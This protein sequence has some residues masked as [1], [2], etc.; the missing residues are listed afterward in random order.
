MINDR[1]LIKKKLGVGRSSVFLCQDKEYPGNVM[2]MKI[3]PPDAEETESRFFIGEYFTLK[4]LNHPNIIKANELGTVVKIDNDNEGISLGSKY[5][6]LEYF[7]GQSLLDYDELNYEEVLIEIIKQLC[8]VLYYIHQS[9]YIY[10]D[11]KPENILIKK[12][13]GRPLIKLIDLGFSQYIVDNKENII[14]GTAEYIAPEILKNE[15]HD[16]RVDLYSLGIVLYRIIYKCFPFETENELD[17]YK[18]HI[19]KNFDFPSSKYSKKIISVLKKL[20]SKNPNERYQDTLQLL[21]ALNI[22][23]DDSLTKDWAPARIFSNR[24]DVLTILKTYIADRTSGEIFTIRGFEGSGK[25]AIVEQIYS[26]YDNVVFINSGNTKS[27]R[28]FINFIIKQLLYKEFIYPNLD[29]KLTGKIKSFFEHETIEFIDELKSIITGM[30]KKN[31]FIFIMDNFN[32]YD[33]FT[34]EVLKNL[35]P[36]FQVNK[37]K[38]ILTET[39][40]FNYKSDFINNLREVNLTPFTDIQVEEYVERSFYRGFP[41]KELNNLILVYADLLP[42]S[43]VSFI[44]DIILLK[45]IKFSGDGASL[46]SDERS[47]KL[48][49]SSHE[50]IY[51]I[52][53]KNLK[54]E[55]LKAA[56]TLSVFN[57]NINT[58]DLASILNLPVDETQLLV[59][60][61]RYKNIFVQFRDSE[62][63]VFISEGLRKYVY[64]EIR[65]KAHFHLTIA[66]KIIDKLPGFNRMSL[67]RHFKLGEDYKRSYEVLEQE[68]AEAEKISA[69]SYQ[70]NILQ[71]LETYPFP[72]PIHL[73]IEYNLARTLFLTSEYS[74]TIKLTDKLLKKIK[75]PDK[76]EKL[77]G[78]KGISLINSGKVEDGVKILEEVILKIKSESEK[79]ALLLEV[80][81]AEIDLNMFD[82][83]IEICNNIIDNSNTLPLEKGKCYNLL[84]LVELYRDNNLDGALKYFKNAEEIYGQT[85]ALFRLAQME[86]NIGNIYNMKGE[87]SEAGRFWNKSLKI[88]SSIG[89]L[90]QE[91]RL[92]LNFG[93]YHYDNLNFDKAV[94]FYERASSIFISVGNTQGEGLVQYN[95]GEI[96]YLTCN[97]QKAFD[98][99][100]I[101][102]EIATVLQNTNEEL[103]TLFLLGKFYYT[104]GDSDKLKVILYDFKKLL[105]KEALAEKHKNNYNYLKILSIFKTNISNDLV[106]GLREVR[107]IFLEDESKYDFF[108]ATVNLV[109]LLL[110]LNLSGEAYNELCADEFDELCSNNY[111]FEAERYL[112]LGRISAKDLS[113]K[114]DP[115]IDYYMRSYN[116]IE[117]TSITELTWR[118]LY[119]IATYYIDRGNFLKAND[120]IKY[121]KSLMIFISE[122]IK[123]N[124]LK[125]IY[126]EMPVRKSGM[127]I[128]EKY[129][130]LS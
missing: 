88:N 12:T 100:K 98:S 94:E 49:K 35:L 27:G 103:E 19:E 50:E 128:L 28:D 104:I 58:A 61:L 37:C 122:S 41:R 44:R 110:K 121:S 48:L 9:N 20:L 117:E 127:E 18:S 73:E 11:L 39:S 15:V 68:I 34:L 59:E 55:E 130:M 71:E 67:A 93:V 70:K 75:F 7:D 51:S 1:Y 2:A 3:L 97:Y 82:R 118:V 96:Y 106:I 126:L 46:K 123:D 45:I 13:K 108:S 53:L 8:S 105:G 66:N 77:L 36:I 95:L 25:T 112:L 124:Q 40:D 78:W 57:I 31:N 113:L 87:H 14:R 80:A 6:T 89:N 72:E 125:T 129:E 5:I 76:K 63:P 33:Q 30:I 24:K 52:R 84:G 43:I 111:L 29:E 92:L 32:S 16:Q 107:K 4:R 42:G 90:E 26:I 99:L 102:R 22:P 91:A 116:L 10:Y 86:M 81:G 115:S 17:I 47:I 101:S 79:Q 56:Q 119:A 109:E 21:N 74:S 38:V 85:E 120:Y 114:L 23:I 69:Y 54:P 60:N 83:T 64:S 65:N 62:D